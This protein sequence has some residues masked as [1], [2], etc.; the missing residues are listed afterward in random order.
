MDLQTVIIT[1]IY[2][3]SIIGKSIIITVILLLL[4]WVLSGENAYRTNGNNR[5]ETNTDYDVGKPITD[6]T[7]AIVLLR[8]LR[9]II[10][11]IIII[12]TIVAH[13]RDVCFPDSFHCTIHLVHGTAVQFLHRYRAQRYKYLAVI[14]EPL[15]STVDNPFFI[16]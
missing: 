7:I 14:R 13:L 1:I 2:T 5:A 11:I 16:I 15:E 3:V 12:I 10:I 8:L 9:I 6:D 4:L